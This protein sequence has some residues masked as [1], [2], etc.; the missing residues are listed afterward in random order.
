[1]DVLREDFHVL[2][3]I[4]SALLVP[5]SESVEDFV[6]YDTFVLAIKTNGDI[7]RPSNL[8]DIRITPAKDNRIRV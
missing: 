3:T 7:L 2:V 6:Y 8:A 5:S 1:M 4:R